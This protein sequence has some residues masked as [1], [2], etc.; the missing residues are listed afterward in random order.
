MQALAISITSE[1]S[2]KFLTIFVGHLKQQLESLNW[3][4][5]FVCIVSKLEGK[6]IC[7]KET[8]IYTICCKFCNL[9]SVYLSIRMT[10]V[11]LVMCRN[12]DEV[13]NL[14]I[15]IVNDIEGDKLWLDNFYR[16]LFVPGAIL[17]LI[18]QCWEKSP[19]NLLH[20]N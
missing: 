1:N 6:S 2:L 3:Y 16:Y 20:L 19:L 17:V 15:T 5:W 14:L 13:R 10:V 7:N 8:F 9:S 4:H 12:L 18:F 11:T